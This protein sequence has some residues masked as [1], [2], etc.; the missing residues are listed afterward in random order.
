MSCRWWRSCYAACS[1]FSSSVDMR[2]L[3][4]WLYLPDW[5]NYS[6]PLEDLSQRSSCPS[7]L[8]G[9]SSWPDPAALRPWQCMHEV[10]AIMYS[11]HVCKT[12]GIFLTRSISTK[13]RRKPMSAN[14]AKEVVPVIRGSRMCWHPA[15]RW[16]RFRWSGPSIAVGGESFFLAV[17]PKRFPLLRLIST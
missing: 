17:Q 9:M 13:V 7:K 10:K 5:V 14:C 16:K 6:R 4:L 12:P 11:L 15:W 3:S 8:R 1:I 2:L